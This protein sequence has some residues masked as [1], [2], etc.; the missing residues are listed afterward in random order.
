M[1]QLTEIFGNKKILRI[2]QFF[3]D[4]SSIEV[5]QTELIGKTKI[6]KATAVK[7]LGL[8]VKDNFLLC[9]RIA[10]T[11]LYR[12]NNENLIVKQLKIT[13]TL[14]QL[15]PLNKLKAKGLEVYLYGSSSRG[16]DTEQSDI[17][18]LVI[19]NVKRSEIINLID[20]IS[21]NINRKIS[22]NVFTGV[23]WSMMQKKDKAYYE[24]VEKDKV[25]II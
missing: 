3:I 1:V 14:L 5:S 12:L 18:I 4:N 24:R 21:K 20:S 6:A 2:L 10:V 9:K 19:G 22:F 11:N 16:E 23:E 25:R 8:L 7:W 13:N 17:D 15:Q